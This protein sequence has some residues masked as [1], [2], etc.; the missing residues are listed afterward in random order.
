MELRGARGWEMRDESDVVV[1]ARSG[2]GWGRRKMERGKRNEASPRESE[3]VFV[4]LNGKGQEE[5]FWKKCSQDS[6]ECSGG[7][8][9]RFER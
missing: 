1:K 2:G 5:D 7:V 6:L 9:A 4:A 8:D 3:T